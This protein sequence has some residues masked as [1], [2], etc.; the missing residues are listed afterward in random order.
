M[1]NRSRGCGVK[2]SGNFQEE[3]SFLVGDALRG[4]RTSSLT[5]CCPPRL[6]GSSYV[7]LKNLGPTKGKSLCLQIPKIKLRWRFWTFSDSLFI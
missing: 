1:D 2:F 7:T 3:L 5:S 6:V 4:P